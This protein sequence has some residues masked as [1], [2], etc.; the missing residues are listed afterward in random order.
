MCYLGDPD[1]QFVSLA[2]GFGVAG[3]VVEKPAALRPALERARAA[4]R[5]GQPYLLDVHMERIGSSRQF[6]VAS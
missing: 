6:I 5:R 1:I 2:A 3:E 4:N